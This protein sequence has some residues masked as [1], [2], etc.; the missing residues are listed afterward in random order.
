MTIF[1]DVLVPYDFSPDADSA[2]RVALQLGREEHGR[3]TVLHAIPVLSRVIGVPPGV[4]PPAVLSAALPADQLRRLEA[5][6]A[7]ARRRRTAP[8]VVSRVVVADPVAA[9]LD[10]ATSST[11]IVMGTLGLTG[12]SHLVIG[13]VAEKVV[14]HAG[15]PVLTIHAGLQMVAQ[16]RRRLGVRRGR[17]SSHIRP[18]RGDRRRRVA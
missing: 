9:I 13:S 4:F 2:L 15:V 16:P 18:R 12:L 14:R 8:A 5:R 3:V 10:A 1:R 11:A 6:V 7:R 17:G